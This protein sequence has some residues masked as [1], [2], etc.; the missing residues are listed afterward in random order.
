MSEQLLRDLADFDRAL[1]DHVRV[2][3]FLH[4]EHGAASAAAK[5][6]YDAFAAGHP[7]VPTLLVDVGEAAAVARAIA[8]RTGIAH[9][10]PQ[11][12]LFQ[13][14]QPVWR[15]RHQAVT[16]GALAAAWATPCC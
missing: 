8:D 7:D 10:A 6:A 2:L 16:A 1:R 3:L 5:G 11:A 4:S 15:A 13:Q 12:I 14:G 9:E